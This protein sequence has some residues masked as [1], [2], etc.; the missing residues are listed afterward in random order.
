MNPKLGDLVCCAKASIQRPSARVNHN[1]TD[2]PFFKMR[3]GPGRIGFCRRAA[4]RDAQGLAGRDG[5][6]RGGLPAV[7]ELPGGH[8]HQPVAQP[9][10]GAYERR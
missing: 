2:A 4:G 5:P 7:E 10:G 9:L 1:F 8:S 6:P 3:P